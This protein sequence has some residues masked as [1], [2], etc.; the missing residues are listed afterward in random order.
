MS[1]REIIGF[2]KITRDITE[3]R[4]AQLALQEAEKQ[5]AHAQKMDALGQLTGGVAHDFN[6]MLMV[7]GG[8]IQTV[9]KVAAGNPKVARAA[10]A[11][12]LAVQR[13]GALTRQLLT[14]ARRQNI[15]PTVIKIGRQIE[16]IRNM[17]ASSLGGSVNLNTTIDEDVWPVKVDENEFE[18]ALVNL[19]LNARDALP[20]G[21]TVSITA[22]NVHLKCNE[23][24]VQVD[25]DFVAI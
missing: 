23:T 24:K 14:F 9:Q 11:I 7:I 5:R 2:A 3:R 16:A 1:R 10:E 17:L 8:H 25:G 4:E 13:G 12:A 19:V 15:H 18:L 6:N 21:G 20:T 22:E